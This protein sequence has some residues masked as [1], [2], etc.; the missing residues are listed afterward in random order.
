MTVNIDGDNSGMSLGYLIQYALLPCPAYYPEI[1]TGGKN[2]LVIES[3]LDISHLPLD[4]SCV[5]TLTGDDYIESP[6]YPYPAPS[7][8]CR[9]FIQKRNSDICQIK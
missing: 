8:L 6:D 7:G 3:E 2:Q 5:M 4:N 1:P 9:H